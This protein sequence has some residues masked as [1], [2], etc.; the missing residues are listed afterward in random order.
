MFEVEQ[1]SLAP[2]PGNVNQPSLPENKFD[3]EM[4]EVPLFSPLEGCPAPTPLL[5]DADFECIDAFQVEP[6]LSLA[7]TSTNHT[8]QIV[9]GKV[10]VGLGLGLDNLTEASVESQA[11]PPEP[12]PTTG[13]H[14]Y[15]RLLKTIVN[16]SQIFTGR[17]N[18]VSGDE[19]ITD[20]KVS[21]PPVTDFYLQAQKSLNLEPLGVHCSEDS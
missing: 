8:S 14:I 20:G 2:L 10:L 18:L 19:S 13:M 11:L 17:H 5:P 6:M 3:I 21:L 7:H 16:V 4:D 9:S 12:S 1:T 15:S